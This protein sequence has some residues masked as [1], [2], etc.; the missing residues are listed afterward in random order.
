[1]KLEHLNATVRKLEGSRVSNASLCAHSLGV[2]FGG[3][4]QTMNQIS[5]D[6]GVGWELTLNGSC[7]LR[8]EEPAKYEA[9]FISEADWEAYNTQE[10]LLEPIV[11]QLIGKML[12][13]IA[14]GPKLSQLRLEFTDGYSVQSLDGVEH[15][16]YR[17]GGENKHLWVQHNRVSNLVRPTGEIIATRH[18]TFERENGNL[19]GTL[20]LSRP[21]P[22]SKIRGSEEVYV[23]IEIETPFG[24]FRSHVDGVDG[25]QAL[26][27]SLLI[28]EVEID[29]IAEANG[30]K[31][32]HISPNRS[33]VY[34]YSDEFNVIHALLGR[35]YNKVMHWKASGNDPDVGENLKL[36]KSCLDRIELHGVKAVSK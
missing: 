8:V 31:V 32:Y 22:I 17:N 13:S 33:V 11:K 35:V 7:L 1:M 5:I 18:F 16:Y 26:Q 23:A 4:L 25:I 21:L 29:K 19:P 28:A 2:Y 6:L 14:V 9:D 36:I 3:D 24:T 12:V 20:S 27:L 34:K 30:A 10:A 15:W